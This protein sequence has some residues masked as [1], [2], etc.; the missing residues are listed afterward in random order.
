MYSVPNFGSNRLFEQ[1]KLAVRNTKLTTCF[2][3]VF[4]NMQ[5]GKHINLKLAGIL[6]A[7]LFIF[8][9]ATPQEAGTVQIGRLKY[10]G[11]GDWYANPTSLPNLI[12]FT[13]RN[14][15]T[16]MPAEAATVEAGSPEIFN[17]P[18]LYMTGHGNVAFNQHEA[19]NL[20][21]YLIGGG[22]LHID[23]NY[24][25]D[26]YIRKELKKVFPDQ[27]LVELPYDHAIYHQAFE[28]NNGPPKIHKHDGKPSQGFGI[29]H[30]GRLVLYY[31]YETDLG[32]GWEDKEVH[33]NPQEKR[34]KAL[35]M[36]ANIIQYVFMY[37]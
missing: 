19:N 5:K 15:G 9:S 28:F 6:L 17:Y 27:E 2:S 12:E 23:D 7:S 29:I 30:K 35:K 1:I 13:N 16:N 14:I 25:M 11:G 26:Q 22:F 21:N 31:T 3:R 36:G 8:Q 33:N 24:G 10:R 20:R 32:D 4:I 34:M 18:L 37:N